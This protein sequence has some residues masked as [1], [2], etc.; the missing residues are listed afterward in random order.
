MTDFYIIWKQHRSRVFMFNFEQAYAD[1][2]VSSVLTLD[3]FL[4]FGSGN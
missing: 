4:F 1:I 3:R 2:L